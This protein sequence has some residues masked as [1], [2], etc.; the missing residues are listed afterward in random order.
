M[1]TR[2][3]R[4]EGRE[5]TP[6]SEEQCWGRRRDHVLPWRQQ[7][8][9]VRGRKVHSSVYRAQTPRP[10]AIFTEEELNYVLGNLGWEVNNI[11]MD[12]VWGKIPMSLESLKVA[13][14]CHSSQWSRRVVTILSGS[15]IGAEGNCKVAVTGVRWPHLPKRRVLSTARVHAPPR[16]SPTTDPGAATIIPILQT[17][18]F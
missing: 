9:E 2:L 8:A 3:E 17:K 13:P 4:R 11:K 12:L 18:E 1:N 10:S 15:V 14:N 7:P 16:F 6:S 5:C